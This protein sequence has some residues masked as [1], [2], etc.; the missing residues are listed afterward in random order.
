[1]LNPSQAGNKLIGKGSFWNLSLGNGWVDNGSSSGKACTLALPTTRQHPHLLL[2]GE[3]HSNLISFS[4]PTASCLC[5]VAMF[6]HIPFGAKIF[7]T[8]LARKI[9]VFV[10]C[11]AGGSLFRKGFGLSSMFH[12]LLLQET[13][14]SWNGKNKKCQKDKIILHFGHIYSLFS[15]RCVTTLCGSLLVTFI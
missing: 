11:L 12:F 8:L 13:V 10:W 3:Q 1:M 6:Q 15:R 14:N 9:I 7:G 2:Q 4:L 5:T